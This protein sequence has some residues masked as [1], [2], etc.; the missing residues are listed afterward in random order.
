MKSETRNFDAIII[1]SGI[2]GLVTASQLAAKGANVL[3]LE[4]YII[5][6]GSGGSF[7]RNGYTFDVG[8][9]M[10]FGFGE[11]GY[12][13]LLTRAL[14]DVNE[15]CETIP[16]PVQ[17]E[18]HLPNNFSISVDKNYEKFIDKLSSFF[19]KEKYGIKKFYDTCTRVFNCLDS[20][21]LLSIEDPSYLLKVFFRSPLSCLGLARWLPIN[22]GDVARKFIKDPKLL[23]FIDIECFCWSVM[24]ALKTPMINAGMVFTDRHVG[25][26]NYPKGGVGKIAEKLVSGIEK[27][28]SKIRYKANVVEILLEDNKAIG[29]KLSNGEKIY[30]NII[31]SNSTRWDTF[32]LKNKKKGLIS[33]KSVP[34]SEYKWSETYKPSPSFVSIHLGVEKTLISDNFNCHHIIVEDW[35]DLENEKGVIFISI[36]TLLDSSLAPEGKHILHAFTPSSMEEWESLSRKD[37]LQKKEEYFSFLIEKISKILPNLDQNIDHKEIGTPKTHR[38]F[39]GRYDGTYGPIPNKK[40]LGLLPMPFNTTNIKNLYCVGDSCFPGQGLNAVAF[41][42]FACAHKIGSKININSSKLPD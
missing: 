4:K 32:G 8:A 22:A 3:V 39:L 20:M 38:K 30:S 17:L 24:P 1:G 37:Y 5:P 2:G 25:G 6:G 40:L 11:K 26:I 12:T 18:Y 27:L 10:I 15:K 28:G 31:V 21:P 35:D 41:S 9:S 36:P 7:K 34:K 19:P 14:K 29:V 42:G 33:S 23:K 13:N 16:D